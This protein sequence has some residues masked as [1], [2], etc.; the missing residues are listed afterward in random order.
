ME[1]QERWYEQFSS[2]STPSS[3]C[4]SSRHTPVQRR[5]SVKPETSQTPTSSRSA[6]GIIDEVHNRLLS[7]QKTQS[8]GLPPDGPDTSF[9][10]RQQ[11]QST[12]E[13]AESPMF[14]PPV[15]NRTQSMGL[16]AEVPSQ[17][18]MVTP[19]PAITA[20]R[21]QLFGSIMQQIPE[22][23]IYNRHREETSKQKGWDHITSQGDAFLLQSAA[24]RT[25]QTLASYKTG[26]SLEPALMQPPSY[27]EA[28]NERGQL[29]ESQTTMT[30]E[31]QTGVRRKTSQ[32]DGRPKIGESPMT[33]TIQLREGVIGMEL[34]P[35]SGCRDGGGRPGSTY[36]SSAQGEVTLSRMSGQDGVSQI[37]PGSNQGRGG[38]QLTSAV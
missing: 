29:I 11:A 2:R 34:L 20:L 38:R 17:S 24:A 9:D 14:S 32:L 35:D 27:R 36:V 4:R 18:P 8:T 7:L 19:K 28:L 25:E 1:N 23:G 37:H 12:P 5:T 33:T 26:V 6:T 16:Q 3:R 21:Q 10:L 13:R 30:S 31:L 22:D 15:P